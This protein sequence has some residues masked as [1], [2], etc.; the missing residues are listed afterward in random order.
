MS[1]R[2]YSLDLIHSYSTLPLGSK[3]FATF[4]F[5]AGAAKGCPG[6]ADPNNLCEKAGKYIYLFLASS[7]IH[8]SF[9]IPLFFRSTKLEPSFLQHFPMPGDWCQQQFLVNNFLL[10]ARQT[11]FPLKTSSLPDVQISHGEV[12][13]GSEA[14]DKDERFPAL[15]VSGPFLHE[16]LCLRGIQQ[17]TLHPKHAIT[18][19]PFH[20]GQVTPY[21]YLKKIITLSCPSF[22]VVLHYSTDAA[23]LEQLFSDAPPD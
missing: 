16:K 1:L 21:L 8:A 14:R 11:C 12:S 13:M 19:L 9:Q 17:D 5:F 15:Q 3:G 7:V 2:P 4:F 20:S 10:T 18:S 23:I 6:A 22:R